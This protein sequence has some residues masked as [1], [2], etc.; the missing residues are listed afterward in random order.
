MHPSPA[1]Q[2]RHDGR[3][4]CRS[5]VAHPADHVGECREIGHAVLEEVADAVGSKLQEG[6]GMLGLD[7]LGEDENVDLAVLLPDPP[8]GHQAF[9]GMGGGHADVDDGQLCGVGTELPEQ[10]LPVTCL[11]DDLEPDLSEHPG[12]PFAEE[13]RV[14]GQ[15]QAHGSLAITCVP[16]PWGLSTVSA[17]PTA[18]ALSASPHSPDPRAASA[19]PTPSSRTL[20]SRCPSHRA[21]AI[22]TEDARACLAALTSASETMKYAVASTVEGSRSLGATATLAGTGDRSARESRAGRRPPSVRTA[23][24]MPRARFL[25]SSSVSDSWSVRSSSAEET[26]ARA[27]LADSDAL[28][29]NAPNWRA[30]VTRRC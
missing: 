22:V 29:L 28:A 21:T 2:L 14:V 10:R 15:N 30:M 4:D 3:V 18:A 8:C 23:G 6:E 17:P 12:Q 20:T 19:P 5:T 7:V 27:G 9:D 24:W 1:H 16:P 13:H 26:G 25:R 11:S